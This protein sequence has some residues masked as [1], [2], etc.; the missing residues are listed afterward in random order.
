[1]TLDMHPEA[2]PPL[3][4]APFAL[5]WPALL[6]ELRPFLATSPSPVYLVGGAVRD[7]FLRRP[8][9]DLDFAGAAD[10]R[11]LAK[12][13]ADKLGGAYYPLDAD[14]GV[15]RAILKR[16][17]ERFVID[18]AR[19][20]GESLAED[21]AGRDF[22]IN[23]LAVPTDGD[24][25]SVIDL[26][27]G[28]VDLQQKRL[29]RC[30]EHSIADDP[31]RALRA[32]R[33]S[34]ALNLLIE[35][36]TRADLRTY[37]PQIASVSAERVR[38]EF[39]NILGGTRPHVALRTLDALG[40]LSLVVPE[41]EAM[42]G[43][44][45]SLPHTQDVWG[46][47]L[48]VV[49]R[50]YGVL[51]TISPAR[52]EDSAADSA[53]GMIVYLLDRFRK[54]WQS[55]L[56]MPQASGHSVQSLLMLAALL[57]DCGK[58]ATRSVEEQGHIHFYKHELV[59][60]DLAQTRCTALR[61]SNDE[62]SRVTEI[63]RQHMRPLHLASSAP[64]NKGE[65]SRRAIYRFWKATG[66]TGLDVCLLTLADYLGMVGV[67]LVLQDWI[68]HLQIVAV[69]LDGY[70]NQKEIIVAP[71]PLVNGRDLIIGLD[72]QPGPQL[73]QVL[74]ALGEAQAAGEITTIEEAFTLAKTL[75][76]LSD[77]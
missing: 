42:R 76:N 44:T 22:T 51:A 15:G 11:K 34:V 43:V 69:L 56:D 49:E 12:L 7:A 54:Q 65:L 53:Y 8:I 29:R 58:P 14:R 17:S 46:H 31:V 28:I 67:N 13:I 71:P 57:H 38:D 41:I 72:L 20:R 32:V 61:L 25:Q 30:N 52:T 48:S 1:M 45:Q 27:G 3:Q 19:F 62:N 2:L 74:D 64:Y 37:G 73:G 40:L 10:G 18:V 16:G 47:T 77:N 4:P 59:G 66:E 60:A 6:E 24:F 33:F 35:P 75:L 50:L 55:H 39:M 68:H 9:H 26:V 23:A 63:V 36:Q 5:G 21:L 70:F